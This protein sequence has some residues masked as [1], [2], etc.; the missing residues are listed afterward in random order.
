MGF[1]YKPPLETQLHSIGA[2]SDTLPAVRGVVLYNL[3]CMAAPYPQ[4]WELADNR[5]RGFLDNTGF[6]TAMDAIALA[7]MVRHCA[8]RSTL[9]YMTGPRTALTE[10]AQSWSGSSYG[11]EQPDWV[12]LSPCK[13]LLV[14]VAVWTL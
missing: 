3:Y 14:G 9:W 13:S 6:Y 1:G 7:Q 5:K 10:P 8:R 4:V 12:A 2:L 11:D